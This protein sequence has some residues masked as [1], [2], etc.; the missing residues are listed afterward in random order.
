M[1]KDFEGWLFFK[2]WEKISPGEAGN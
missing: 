1:N 2:G